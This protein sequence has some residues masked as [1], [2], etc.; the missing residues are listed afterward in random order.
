[1]LY[2]EPYLLFENEDL[3]VFSKPPY[4]IMDTSRNYRKILKD[5]INEMYKSN[6]KPYLLFI[7]KYLKDN[8]NINAYG[9]GYNCCH[10]LDIHTSGCVLVS[11]KPSY[12]HNCRKIINNKDTTFKIYVCL[13]KG[14]LSNKKGFIYKNI[15]C[16]K[17]LPTYCNTLIFNKNSK[18]SLPSISYY[19]V[20]NE[21]SYKNVF[22]SLVC[23]RIFTGRTHQIRVHMKSLGNPIILDDRY[24]HNT[25]TDKELIDRMFLHNIYLSFLYKNNRVKVEVPLPIDI[26]K[27][28]NKLK[29][30]KKYNFLLSIFLKK[31]PNVPLNF[32]R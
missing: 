5:K 2:M 11:K 14:L 29:L 27:C 8:Y 31:I 12:Y 10:R 25:K 22:Y 20:L 28:L 26:K 13:V 4:Y 24:S 17:K 30:E 15:K 32:N 7:R 3:L 1:M 9:P 21:Y 6:R 23:V 16:S 18:N 19:Q